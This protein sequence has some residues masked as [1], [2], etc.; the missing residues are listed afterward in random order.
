MGGEGERHGPEEEEEGDQGY[1]EAAEGQQEEGQPVAGGG[2]GVGG[3]SRQAQGGGVSTLSYA[4][5][6]MRA[7]RA[8]RSRTV[9]DL[10]HVLAHEFM[11]NSNLIHVQFMYVL[12]LLYFLPSSSLLRRVYTVPHHAD[13]RKC[14]NG[15][16]W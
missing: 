7:P 16:A 11:Y 9:R 10:I 1:R 6:R 14:C 5:D 2:L 3:P 4:L 13:A 15:R 12:V 8:A